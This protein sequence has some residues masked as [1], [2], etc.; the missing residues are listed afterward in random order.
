MINK[1]NYYQYQPPV[2]MFSMADFGFY[3]WVGRKGGDILEW[4]INNFDKKNPRYQN[5]PGFKAETDRY[6]DNINK[7]RIDPEY[8]RVVGKRITKIYG[9]T[10]LGLAA[11]GAGAYFLR[12]RRTKKGKQII[13][14]VRQ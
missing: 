8:N 4:Q 10:A 7:S 5:D 13:E 2:A 14:R 12:R 11:V 3:D 9:A 1:L 6:V